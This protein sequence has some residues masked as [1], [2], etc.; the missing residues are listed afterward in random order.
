VSSGVRSPKFHRY[1]AIPFDEVE[2]APSKVKIVGLVGLVALLV[3]VWLDGLTVKLAVGAAE[4]PPPPE[5]GSVT[6][7]TVDPD[8]L[9]PAESVATAVTV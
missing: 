3:P 9:L 4:P 6:T 5:P 2:P 8:P 1:S 7:I